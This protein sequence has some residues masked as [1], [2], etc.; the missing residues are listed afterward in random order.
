MRSRRRAPDDFEAALRARGVTLIAGL[1]EAGRGCWAGPVWAGAVILP[2]SGDFSGIDD[3]KMLSADAREDAYQRIAGGLAVS[4][5]AG[6]ASATEVDDLGIVPATHLAMRRALGALSPAP[7]HLLVDA[8]TLSQ[9]ALPQTA[10][11]RGD[12]RSVSIAAASV[13]AK[14]TR[15]RWMRDAAERDFPGYGFAAHKGY[16][17][18]QHA[19]ALN[20]LGP[21][22]L[23]RHTFAPVARVAAARENRRGA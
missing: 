7:Q 4:W 21:C 13:I 1:D 19:Q 16:G 10:I 22:A 5:A 3:S 11:I 20:E 9:T 18:L 8:L 2:E 17:T 23:H 6:Q 14:V 15:D 12:S